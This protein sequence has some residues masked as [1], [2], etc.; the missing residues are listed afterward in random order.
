MARYKV[1]KSVAHG[2]AHSFTSTLNYRDDDYVLGHFLR[3]ARE[4][5]SGSLRADILTGEA[6]PDSLVAQPVRDAIASYR[7]FFE[8]LV[9]SHGTSMEVVRAAGMTL[10]FDLSTRRPVAHDPRFHESP[11]TCRVEI[12]DDRGKRWSAEAAGWWYLEAGDLS[13]AVELPLT[14]A[15]AGDTMRQRL[16]RIIGRWW[17]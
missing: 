16:R 11:Y 5:G 13:Y 4:A 14:P 6:A 15:G 3:Q 7:K 1:L 12:E 2:Y 8:H 10:D 17:R 9:Q